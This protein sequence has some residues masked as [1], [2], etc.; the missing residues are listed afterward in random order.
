MILHTA[1]LKFMYCKRFELFSSS[2]AAAVMNKNDNSVYISDSGKQISGKKQFQWH[3]DVHI[4]SVCDSSFDLKGMGMV[5]W[6]Y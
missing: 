6:M 3:K 2:L 5:E 4:F 1:W